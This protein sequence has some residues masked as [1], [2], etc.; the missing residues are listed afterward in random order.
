MLQFSIN[1]E[2]NNFIKITIEKD[3]EFPETTSVF[4]GYDIETIVEIKSSNYYVKGKTWASTGNIYD[5]Y[6]SLKICQKK[7]SGQVK[8]ETYE[9]NLSFSLEYDSLG[10]VN[11]SG[12]F[13]ENFVENNVLKF[14]FKTDQ[15]FISKTIDELEIIYQKY[16]DN[17]GLK[18]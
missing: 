12:V 13:T 8:F 11:V 7:I 2:P 18:K 17:Q 6:N 14:E 3:Y 1:G 9:D 15:T 16:G 10:H 5:F 4:G